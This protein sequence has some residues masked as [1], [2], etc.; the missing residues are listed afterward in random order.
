MLCGMET[1]I[2][3]SP[4]ELPKEPLENPNR[5][6]INFVVS[7]YPAE[8]MLEIINN[9][10]QNRHLIIYENASNIVNSSQKTGR[11]RCDESKHFVKVSA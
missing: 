2:P 9:S 6:C 4:R 1:N 10:L 5:D 11:T 7:G 3:Q 8:L